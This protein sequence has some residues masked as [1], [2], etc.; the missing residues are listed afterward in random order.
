MDN[1]AIVDPEQSLDNGHTDSAYTVVYKFLV[2]WILPLQTGLFFSVFSVQTSSELI[3]A[4]F[5][6]QF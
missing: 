6:S 4:I 3:T 1:G 5:L 2:Q